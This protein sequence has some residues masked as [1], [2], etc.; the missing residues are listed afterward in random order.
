MSL[1]GSL[2][3]NYTIA[4][5]VGQNLAFMALGLG[6]LVN[7]FNGQFPSNLEQNRIVDGTELQPQS[8]PWQA[9]LWAKMP[10]CGATIL[11]ER[12]VMTAVGCVD[13]K[14]KK[15]FGNPDVYVGVHNVTKEE[16]P[17]RSKHGIKKIHTHKKYRETDFAGFYY[18]FAILELNETI[19]FSEW[20]KALSLPSPQDTVF[21]EKTV[22]VISGWGQVTEGLENWQPS[23]VLL[24]AT[25]AWISDTACQKEY[26]DSPIA[27]ATL[28]ATITEDMICAGMAGKGA[29]W[30]D[31]GGPL[32]WLDPKTKLV[33]LIGVVSWGWECA[34]VPGVFAKLT[35]VLDWI[36]GVIGDSN[37]EA[38]SKG[39]CMAM[40]DLNGDACQAFQVN[41]IHGSH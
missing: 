37:E 26:D 6:G 8:L 27:N 2:I 3:S 15:L 12:F 18:N 39:N 9:L 21:N 14:R 41:S 40:G 33:K 35:T 31:G 5:S 23:D 10:Y 20:A 1:F 19:K 28:V 34:T 38:C 36:R 22:F 17:T 4:R 7:G 29:C 25:V 16:E 30:G 32:A 11:S 13:E 24:S